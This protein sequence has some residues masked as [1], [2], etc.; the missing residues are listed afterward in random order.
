M[1]V[2]KRFFIRYDYS[3]DLN[4]IKLCPC[5]ELSSYFSIVISKTLEFTIDGISAEN[6]AWYLCQ[7]KEKTDNCAR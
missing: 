5:H 3:N 1:T 4:K 2:K 7:Y 6:M